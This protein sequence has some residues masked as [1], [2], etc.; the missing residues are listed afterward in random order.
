MEVGEGGPQQVLK[1]GTVGKTKLHTG[2]CPHSGAE[3]TRKPVSRDKVGMM[4]VENIV[5]ACSYLKEERER[6]A[7][8][9]GVAVQGGVRSRPGEAGLTGGSRRQRAPSAWRTRSSS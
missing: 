2:L 5:E 4:L 8:V 3:R 1:E 6:L 9:A 7:A